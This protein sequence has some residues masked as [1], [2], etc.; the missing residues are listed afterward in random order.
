MQE[1]KITIVWNTI[2][3]QSQKEKTNSKIYLYVEL[4]P[5]LD[6][7]NKSAPIIWSLQS[8]QKQYF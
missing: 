3:I 7:R 1:L 2:D 6:N 8:C 5:Y 4:R